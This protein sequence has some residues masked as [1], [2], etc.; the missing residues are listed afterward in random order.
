MRGD[1]AEMEV[2]T[3]LMRAGM[4]V[5]RPVSSAGRYDLAIDAGGGAFTRVQCKTG[6]LRKGRI[7]FEFAAPTRAGRSAFRMKA[8]LTPLAC[9]VRSSRPPTSCRWRQ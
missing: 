1:L 3:A 6:I 5:L 2:A 9:T 7:L 4:T 8:W